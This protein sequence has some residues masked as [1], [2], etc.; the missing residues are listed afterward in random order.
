MSRIGE[1]FQYRWPVRQVVRWGLEEEIPGGGTFAYVLGASALF[2]FVIQV[3][4][5]VWQLFFYVPTVDHAYQSVAYIRQEVPYGWLVHGLH[6]WGSNFF[7]II[8]S[9]HMARVFIWGAYKKPRELTW[10]LG[11]VLFLLVL[12]ESFTGALLAWDELG[13]WAAEVGTSIA[14]TVPVIGHFLKMFMR[15]GAAMGQDTLSRFFVL[16]VAILAA[17]LGAV[18]V[19]HIVAFRQFG[20]VGPWTERRRSKIGWFWPEQVLRDTLVIVALFML[21][22]GLCVYCPAPVTGP[23]DHLDN[24]IT[25][26]P[27]WQFLFLYQFLKLFKG[28]WEPVGTT[29]VPLALTLILLLLPFYDR[30]RHR[31][32][33]R[34]PIAMLGG[35]GLVAWLIVYTILGY[36]SH[37][38]AATSAKVSTAGLSG[39]VKAGAELFQKEGCISC[40]TVH[41]QGGN[42]GPNLSNVG[43]QGL[44]RQWLSVQ[45]RHPK[46]HDPSTMM[47]SFDRLSD[48][49]VDELVDFLE[50]L[51]GKGPSGAGSQRQKA[52]R[53]A[54]QPHTG[55]APQPRTQPA[56]QPHGDPSARGD[57]QAGKQ[58]FDA[59]ECIACHTVGGKGG[60]VGPDLS[61]EGAKGRSPQWLTVQIRDPKKHVASSIMP[62]FASLSDRTVANL[63]AYLESLRP[64]AAS[65]PSSRP[66]PSSQPTTLPLRK[67]PGPPGRA[68]YLVGQTSHG[69]GDLGAPQHGKLL[70]DKYCQSCHGPDGRGGVPN[71]GSFAGV[72]PPLAPINPALFSRDPL[73]F[74]QNI[75]RYIQH[76]STPPGAQPAHTMPPWGDN[77]TLS[78]EMISEIEAYI[79]RLNGVDRAAIRHPGV[80]P[81]TFLVL[82]LA[83]LGGTWVLAI[84]GWIAAGVVCRGRD[85]DKGAEQ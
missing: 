84:F 80:E 15:G 14:G 52:S 25:P 17:L 60:K 21:L 64:S 32:P 47:P 48:K 59:H 69:I 42:I 28:R 26:K 46:R 85:G 16:H 23:A 83:I 24:S 31:N 65:R 35:M 4:T 36:Q 81:E 63:V 77:L 68:A 11:V 27:E 53:R 66:A 18:I 54:S 5:G 41:G 73:L 19:V 12:A 37:P 34:R 55:D 62:S 6:Y 39:S 70:Y 1:W 30:G 10:M 71:A 8:V 56:S 58:W 67:W 78:Q 61:D 50:S 82:M 76:G 51:G 9:L 74:A 57:A 2:A 79:L 44:S 33:L 38:G 3:V 72:V 7:I 49:K 40:H 29:G 43:A 45:I 20:S 13:Y 75:D 22:V